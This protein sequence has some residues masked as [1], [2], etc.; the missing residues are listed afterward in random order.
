MCVFVFS[1]E[2]CR[3]PV[4]G[5]MGVEFQFGKPIDRVNIE[6]SMQN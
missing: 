3:K 4:K 2:K 6:P 5:K 1:F